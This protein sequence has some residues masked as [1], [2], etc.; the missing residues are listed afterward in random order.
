MT[1]ARV[2]GADD[3]AAWRDLRLRALVESPSAFGATYAHER[4]FTPDV[5]REQV[6]DPDG[7]CVLAE[8]DGAPV[9]LT[10]GFRD[11]PGL[12]HVVAMWVDPAARGQRV[13]HLLLGAVETWAG[14]RGL[15]LHLDVNTANEP[16]RRSYERYGFVGTGR[17]RPL[18]AGS[19][20]VVEQMVLQRST[21]AVRRA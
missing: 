6:G 2:L 12:L 1:S 21:D 3:W 8:C 11:L 5:W 7:V 4:D 16:A 15:G 19:A 9:G 17:T 14:D 10:G 18:R 20:E 13:A